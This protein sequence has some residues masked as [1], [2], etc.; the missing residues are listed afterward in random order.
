MAIQGATEQNRYNSEVECRQD[1]LELFQDEV[2]S[3]RIANQ[4]MVDSSSQGIL[5]YDYNA[6]ELFFGGTGMPR[7]E[8]RDKYPFSVVIALWDANDMENVRALAKRTSGERF[9]MRLL[10]VHPELV[11]DRKL[12]KDFALHPESQPYEDI[13]GRLTGLSRVEFSGTQAYIEATRMAILKSPGQA[14]SD[15]RIH[16]E[17][18]IEHMTLDLYAMAVRYALL[19]HRGEC[20]KRINL[21]A[22]S[23]FSREE[24]TNHLIENMGVLTGIDIDGFTASEYFQIFGRDLFSE[25]VDKIALYGKAV[26]EHRR[27]YVHGPILDF[28]SGS[29]LSGKLE[30]P[31]PSSLLKHFQKGWDMTFG[32][33]YVHNLELFAEHGG[34]DE[35]QAAKQLLEAVK[36]NKI[37]VKDLGDQVRSPQSDTSG[38]RLVFTG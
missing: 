14:F 16:H 28:K 8:Q 34:T 17:A 2:M 20:L 21:M 4:V 26:S 13:V 7:R 33:N 18:L 5:F 38:F 3:A 15:D 19:M 35:C 6:N 25:V 12:D 1:A 9:L 30:S 31:K 36:T 23:K 32:P 29:V 24:V 11:H 37:L 22:L 27:T 10:G